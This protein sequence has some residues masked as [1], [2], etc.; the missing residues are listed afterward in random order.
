VSARVMTAVAGAAGVLALGGAIG[1]ISAAAAAP[2]PSWRIVKSVHSGAG[3]GFTAVVATGKAA[4]WAFDTAG[5]PTAWQRNGGTWTQVKFPGKSG[6]QVVAAGAASPSDVWAFTDVGT[7]GRAL[8]WNGRTWSVVRTFPQPIGGAAVLAANDVWVFGQPGIIE[9]LGAWRY[10]GHAWT[11]V[12]KN[13]DGG[14]ALAAD[15]VWAFSGANVDHWN[16][17]AWASTSVSGLLPRR[18]MFND[19]AVTGVYAQSARSVY[20]VGNG[21]LQDDGGPTVILH[22]NG[23]TWSKVAQGNFGYGTQPSQQISPDGHG[24]LWLPM[25]GAL[26]A[27]SYLIHYAAG[28]LTAARLP[29]GARSINVESVAAVPGTA[30]VLAGGFTH[31]AGNPFGNVVAVILQYG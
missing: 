27:P 20:A 22:Y 21:N 28:R 1:A 14:S 16:G 2:P 3:G 29:L 31:A 18:T 10:N 15:D 25:P 5:E 26:G 12:A 19:P 6:E 13:L 9:Q 8:R 17:R 24:G 11:R 30:Q 4:G 7:G 23:R